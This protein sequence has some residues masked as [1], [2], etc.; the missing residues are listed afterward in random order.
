MGKK[1]RKDSNKISE[2][3]RS[4]VKE[5]LN[6]FKWNSVPR[7]RIAVSMSFFPR[8]SNSPSLQHLVKFYLDEL[9]SL[10][11]GDDRQVSLIEAEIW[12]TPKAC[13]TIPEKP[14]AHFKI[15]R[16]TNYQRKFDL[17]FEILNLDDF[18][19]EG[20]EDLSSRNRLFDEIEMIDDMLKD[21]GFLEPRLLEHFRRE[22]QE[23]IL[24]LNRIRNFDRPGLN[25]KRVFEDVVI[26]FPNE[27]EPFSVQL[28]S[29]P[30][31]GATRAYKEQ[32]HTNVL[33]LK[34]R[35][36]G[37]Q[38]LQIPFGLDVQVHAVGRYVSKDLDNIMLDILPAIEEEMCLDGAYVSG[39]RV[40]VASLEN[41]S[42]VRDSIRIKLL[43]STEIFDFHRRVDDALDTARDWIDDRLRFF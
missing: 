36:P 40:Y 24:S 38:S 6:D 42:I 31:R 3:F 34:E 4:L 41:K 32:I 27:I 25:R 1:G 18:E 12:E 22:R 5:S 17:F 28:A 8:N 33:R 9:R 2:H 16:L 13:L 20:C 19:F 23:K 10:A 7:A 39:F 29:L 11:F 14:K 21:E 37:L 43:P 30:E 26:R 15:E 35:F